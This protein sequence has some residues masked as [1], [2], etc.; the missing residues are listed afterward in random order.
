M[1]LVQNYTKICQK[2]LTVREFKFGDEVGSFTKSTSEGDPVTVLR[3]LFGSSI[4]PLQRNMYLLLALIVR[5]KGTK[6]KVDEAI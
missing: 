6:R 5:D 2:T 3:K 4:I 1:L